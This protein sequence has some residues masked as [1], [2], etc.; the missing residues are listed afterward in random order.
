MTAKELLNGLLPVL[1]ITQTEAAARVGW[2]KMKLSSKLTKDSLRVSDF[3]DILDACG[4]EVVFKKKETGEEIMLRKSGHGHRMKG[5]ADG[6][7]F[8]TALSTALSNT[9]YADG[10]N[11]YDQNGEAQELYIDQEGRYFI[12]EYNCKDPKKERIVSAS[13]FV[14][15]AF[16]EKYGTE[17]E[18]KASADE[19]QP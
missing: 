10:E 5:M 16:I 3:M 17:I 4:V 6:V 14:A 8:N 13:H 2:G 11:E 19:I 12:A 9:F 1:E 7:I 15:A 18:K